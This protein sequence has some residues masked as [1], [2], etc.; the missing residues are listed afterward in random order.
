MSNVEENNN[1]QLGEEAQPWLMTYAD[2]MTLLFAFFVF[3]P[4]RTYAK[5]PPEMRNQDEME[6]SQNMHGM[7]LNGYE[8][9]KMNLKAFDFGETDLRGAVFNNSQLMG[10]DLKGA[11]M[12]D[13]VAFATSF[14]G[15]DL[16]NANLTNALLMESTFEDA[17]IDGADFTNAVLNRTQQIKLCEIASGSNPSTGIDTRYSLGC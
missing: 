5:T 8:F 7:D 3:F 16:R 15:S 14:V 4:F 9:V 11:N 13:V 6:I 1:D 2:M 10:T 17:L 12:E